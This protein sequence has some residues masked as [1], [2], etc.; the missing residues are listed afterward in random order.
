MTLKTTATR[1]G[2]RGNW[3][4]TTSQ[5]KHGLEKVTIPRDVKGYP[6]ACI[7]TSRW[8]DHVCSL[9]LHIL[10]SQNIIDSNMLKKTNLIPAAITL[11]RRPQTLLL[12]GTHL[13]VFAHLL[14]HWSLLRD[15]FVRWL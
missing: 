7:C 2:F 4:E 9:I 11:V 13:R 8:Q 15:F 6:D 3:F 14:I 10:A 5:P 1:N 12:L